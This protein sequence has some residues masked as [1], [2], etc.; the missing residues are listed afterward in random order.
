MIENYLISPDIAFVLLIIGMLGI[1]IEVS[2]P[3]ASFPGIVGLLALILSIIGFSYF[4]INYFGFVLLLFALIMLI[5]EVKIVSYGIFTFLGIISFGFGSY[6]LIN[7]SSGM[8]ISLSVI[9]L[10]SLMLLAVTILLL[11][12]GLKAQKRKRLGGVDS[13]VGQT[14]I[15][16]KDITPLRIGEIKFMGELWRAKSNENISNGETVEIIKIDNL[17]CFVK[18]TNKYND[19]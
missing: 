10:A 13:I 18:K 1:V 11:F 17:T 4:Q 5:L 15:V 9:I 19:Q 6:I 3:G 16:T 2:A 14:A 7:Q 12:L 8:G